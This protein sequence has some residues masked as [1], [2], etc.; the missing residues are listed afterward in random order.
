MTS[1]PPPQI[2]FDDVRMRGFR[3]RSSVE[4]ALDWIDG[5]AK[6]LDAERV[7]VSSS[8]GRILAEAAASSIDVPS[9]RRAMM[10]GFALHAADTLGAS[11]YNPLKLQVIGQVLPG[12][13]FSGQVQR[14]QAVRIMTGAPLPAGADAVLPVE[15][16]SQQANE[17]TV[18]DAIAPAKHVGDVGEDIRS[19]EVVLCQGRWLRPQDLGVLSSI[20]Y[21]DVPVV[22]RPAVRLVVTGNELCVPGTMPR[23]GQTIDT[24]STM[25]AALVRRDRGVPLMDGLTPDHPDAIRAAMADPSADVVIV[26]GGTSVGQEDHAP[27]ILAEL[28]ELAIHGVAMRPSSPSGMGCIAKRLVFLLPGNPV[29]C[30]CAYDFFAGR[31]IRLLS[32]RTSDWPYL[33]RLGRLTRKISSL[34]GRHDYARVMVDGDRIEPLAIGGASVLSSTTRADGFVVVPADSEGFASGAEVEVYLYDQ[35]IEGR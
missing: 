14:G 13:L 1:K 21:I 11:P 10:D 9:F 2:E 8:V 23:P 26:S 6:T 15:R 32:G 7:P 12:E 3:R 27:R 33:R 5:Q 25:L 20:G 31:A 18:T 17:L 29:S 28:G 30:L 24:N 16:T 35:V 34:I 22:R 4:A 19:G